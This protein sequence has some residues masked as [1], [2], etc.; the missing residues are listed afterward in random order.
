M[1]TFMIINWIAFLAITLYALYLFAKVV[2]T[3]VAYIKLGKKSEFDGEMKLRMQRV[4]KIVFGQSK[5]LK[6][7]K[8]G[9]MHVMMFYGFILVQFGAIDMF[10]KGLSPG[11]HLPF[12]IFYPGFVFFQELVTLMI[13]VAV[14]WAFYRRYMEK[15]VRLKRGFKA[16]LVLIFIATLMFSVLFGNGMAMIWHGHELTWT[17]PVASLIAMAFGW[18]SASGAMVLFYV[19]WWIH[20]ITILTFLVYIPQSKHAHLIAAPINVFLSKNV[21]GKLKKIDFEID[22]E[23]EEE[24]AFGVG[25]VEDFEQHQMLDFYACV[26]C[27]RCTDVCPASGTGKMLSP[28]DI[29]IKV[30]DHLTEKGAAV[31]GKSAWVPSYAFSGATGNVASA[32]NEAA[33]TIQSASLIGDVI[34]AEELSGC[35]TCRNCEDACP[36]NN[37][38]VGT[39]IDM[40]RYLVMTEGKMDSDIQRAVTNIERQGNPWGLS[41]KDRIKWRD[42]DQ[43]IHIPTV[44]ELKKEDKEFEYLFW[45]SSMGAFDSRSQKIALA[46][47]KLMNQA[48]VSFAILGNMEANSGDTARRIGNEFL[49]QEIAEKNIK[50]F[51]KNGVTKIVT[52]DPHAYNIFKNEYP[53]FGFEAEVYHHTQ[54]LYDLVKTGKLKP[55]RAINER[56]TYHDSCY[57]GRYN[58]VYDP[59]REILTAIPGLELVE[60]DRSRENGMCCGAGG[61]LMWTEETTGNRINV[62]RTEQ[63]LAVQP[64]MISSACPYCL[65]MLSDGT[66]AKEVDEDISTMDVAEILALSVFQE[67]QTKTA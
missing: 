39:I 30:R 35:T 49:F 14:A 54:L 28:M 66:K 8:S 23:S 33:A 27:G 65:T 15:L 31:T 13:L 53:D 67:E 32:S 11:N 45:V 59:P 17:E 51:E 9:I 16:G 63:A 24:I 7:K 18:L 19:A 25:K 36:V 44:K 41:K 56:L 47:A 62:A 55:Q 29:M 12:G 1:E 57:L 37:E 4:W 43:S 52:I 64:T 46:F 2:S 6:D 22:E 10:V 40:R 38:H 42:E 60:M 21:P 61:G 26:E 5:L 34:T 48:G 3:R 20:T 58:G 50:Q